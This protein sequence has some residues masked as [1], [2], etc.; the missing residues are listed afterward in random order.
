MLPLIARL[1]GR[2]ASK[3]ELREKLVPRPGLAARPMGKSGS[4]G[5]SGN[6]P[7]GLLVS[8]AASTS[9]EKMHLHAWQH[10]CRYFRQDRH[11]EGASAAVKRAYLLP[12]A[13]AVAATAAELVAAVQAVQNP[14]SQS[15]VLTAQTRPQTQGL[16]V[17]VPQRCCWTGSDQK[18]VCLWRQTLQ[19]LTVQSR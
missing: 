5:A 16:T 19:R 4:F 18:P 17:L 6:W 1:I 12:Q 3:G 13:D 9:F 15:Q 7:Y 8:A 2:G 11:E 10:N 14:W